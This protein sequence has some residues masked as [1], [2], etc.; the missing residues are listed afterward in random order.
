V[1]KVKFQHSLA[2]SGTFAYSQEAPITLHLSH[3]PTHISKASTGN[4]VL[5]TFISSLTWGSKFGYDWT[6]VTD[7]LHEEIRFTVAS[8]I[9]LPQK[10]SDYSTFPLQCNIASVMFSKNITTRIFFPYLCNYLRRTCTELL[11]LLAACMKSEWHGQLSPASHHS[12]L[13][14]I[15]EPMWDLWSIQWYSNRFILPHFDV[16]TITPTTTFIH[17]LENDSSS[18]QT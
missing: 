8:D 13:G 18:Q 3:L 17:G 5:K 14:L 11:V 2:L 4:V 16:T 1:I 9:E 15:P 6:K 7:T 12:S 10:V